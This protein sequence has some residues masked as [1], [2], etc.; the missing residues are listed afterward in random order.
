MSQRGE[1][2]SGERGE[3][4]RRHGA[5]DPLFSLTAA[6]CRGLA[7][8]VAALIGVGCSDKG[9]APEAAIEIAAVSGGGQTGTAGLVLPAA[10]VAEVRDERGE[11]LEGISVRFA[12]TDGGGALTD[13]NVVTGSDGRVAVEWFLG[14]IA[15]PNMANAIVGE[16]SATFSA[17]AAAPSPATTYHGRNQYIE[18]LPGDL[19]IVISAPHGG[20]LVP[21]EIPD[22]TSGT[23][24]RDTNTEE[25]VRTIGDALAALT[26]KR[27]HVIIC[28][29]RRI[30]LDAN[31]EIVEAAQGNR[32]AQRA[33]FEYHSFIDAAKEAVLDGHGRGFYIDLHGHGHEIDRLELG[34]L[35][36]ATELGLAD[37]TI[38]ETTYENRSSIRE[39]S[40][41][42]AAS[43]AGLLRGPT[44]L[45]ALLE[46]QG[47]AAVPSVSQ[48]DPGT[49]PYF[50]GG[51]NTAR[52]G[53]ETA[54]EFSGVQIEAHYEGVRDNA[55]N[56]ATFAAALAAVLDAYLAAHAGLDIRPL[57]R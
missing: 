17:I 51:Y 40:Q 15:G 57:A 47:F 55:T 48:P 14:P 16:H 1:G 35:L 10:L 39:L 43:F 33:W 2:S 41:R 50:S 12:V 56:R 52:H 27:P 34:Y 26:G 38:E 19:P 4:A 49:D 45:G 30:K 8:A 20:T 25:L 6:L 44:S 18:Y 22:R 42:S 21:S 32:L 24:V 31:R 36:S 53:S 37:A 28:R 11:P 54:G 3:G 46:N 23:T 29:L 7:I 5:P 13:T 9:T